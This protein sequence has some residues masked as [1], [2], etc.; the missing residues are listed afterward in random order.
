MYV[1]ESDEILFNDEWVTNSPWI[2]V[3]ITAFHETRHAYQGFCIRNRLNESK[4]TLDKWEYESLNYISPSG[5]NNEIDDAAYI[6]QAIE[7][8]AIV[9]AHKLIYKYFNVKTA[10][11]NKIKRLVEDRLVGDELYGNRSLEE[12][13]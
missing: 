13:N 4:E 2:E 11:P 8:D 1:F 9:F 6:N 12:V 7:I 3:I 5:R 10:I